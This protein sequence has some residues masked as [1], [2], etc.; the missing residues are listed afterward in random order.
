MR[1]KRDALVQAHIQTS[2]NC[3]IAASARVTVTVREG[4]VT[5]RG[6]VAAAA[7]RSA[8]EADARRFSEVLGITNRIVV[9]SHDTETGPSAFSSL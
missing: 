5:L 9:A 2:I 6:R 4:W 7:H 8:A 3:K 1:Q